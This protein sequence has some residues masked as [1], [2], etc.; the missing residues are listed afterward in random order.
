MRRVAKMQAAWSLVTYLLVAACLQG[1]FL[2]ADAVA[3][4]SVRL[5]ATFTPNRL[6]A[7]TTVNFRFNVTSHQAAPA[8][9]LTGLALHMPYGMGLVTSTLGL[10][11]CYP[12]SLTANGLAGCS[13]NAW[14]GLGSAIV[15]VPFGPRRVSEIVDVTVLMGPPSKN[16]ITLM[17]YATGTAPVSAAVVFGGVLR[18]DSRPF[19]EI[20]EAVIPVIPSV[21]EGPDVA[22]SEFGASIGPANLLYEARRHGKSYFFKPRGMTIPRHC[23]RGGFPVAIELQFADGSSANSATKVKCP[24]R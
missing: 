14:M 13:P 1:A 2:Q 23:P 16:G 21:P 8:P 5:H 7:A 4:Q 9:G 22:I 3:S 20:V 11:N 15:K 19:G 10:A 6:G 24:S 12:Q 18:P 17:F